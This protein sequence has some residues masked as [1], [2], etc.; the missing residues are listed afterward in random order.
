MLLQAQTISNNL[1]NGRDDK[2]FYIQ[3]G[4]SDLSVKADE[5]KVRI[6]NLWGGN[7][8]TELCFLRA[9]IPVRE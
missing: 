7:S 2:D 9:L 3:T 6:L 4:I 5:Y 1:V 8:F